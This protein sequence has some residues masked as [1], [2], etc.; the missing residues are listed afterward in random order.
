[1]LNT[2]HHNPN[3]T[4]TIFSQV[5]AGILQMKTNS[6]SGGAT[7]GIQEEYTDDDFFAVI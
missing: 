1:M 7:D 6:I 3:K 4:I 5:F 2:I